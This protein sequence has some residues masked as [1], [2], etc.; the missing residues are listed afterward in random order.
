VRPLRRGP[1][2]LDSKKIEHAFGTPRKYSLL[3]KERNLV[4]FKENKIYLFGWGIQV[5]YAY[6]MHELGTNRDKSRRKGSDI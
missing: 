3:E 1:V 5:D 2:D 6:P 4:D